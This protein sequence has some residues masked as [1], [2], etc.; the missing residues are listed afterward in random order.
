MKILFVASEAHPLIKT[1]GLGD[2]IGSLPMAL[3]SL[4]AEVR[5]LLP[6]YHELRIHCPNAKPVAQVTIAGLSQPVTLLECILPGSRVKI[7]LVDYP[8]MVTCA[9]GLALGQWMR[10]SG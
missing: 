3:Q 4:K 6:A 10:S 7:W 2:V 9:T 8:A 1:G 5:L